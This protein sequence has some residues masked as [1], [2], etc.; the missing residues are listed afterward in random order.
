MS[1]HQGGCQCGQIRFET[2]G[3]NPNIFRCWCKFCQKITGSSHF[4]ELCF[5]KTEFKITSGKPSIFT[6]ISAGSGKEVYVHFCAQCSS[7]IYLSLERWPDT[8]NV[9][10]GTFDDPDWCERT[11]EN[12]RQ[13]F[14]SEAQKGSII[15]AGFPT[16]ENHVLLNDGTELEPIIYDQHR[17][18]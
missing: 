12:T 5:D 13:V 16:F 18:I 8:R 15:P 6:T 7:K 4:V 9:F 14:V 1:A 3:D 2:T 17:V 10:I 11:P